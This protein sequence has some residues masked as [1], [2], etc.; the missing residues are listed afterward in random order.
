MALSTVAHIRGASY[1]DVQ[2]I[3][4]DEFIPEK[5][6][7]PI[8]E[9]AACLLNCYETINRN[10]ELDGRPPV[11]LVGLANSNDAGNPIFTE[12]GL[13]SKVE[14]MKKK[15]QVYSL[16]YQRGI[17]IFMLDSS[18][19]SKEK[20]QTALYKMTAGSDFEQMALANEFDDFRYQDNIKSM[21]LA[22][23]KP[24]CIAGELCFYKHKSKNEYYCST[25]R[26]GSPDSYHATSKDLARWRRKYSYL[27]A[28]Y[29][30][31]IITFES[32]TTEIIFNKYIEM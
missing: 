3:I 19:I 24:I 18:R 27:W 8:K 23:Y 6:M 11:Q 29:L 32:A 21:P 16:D 25:T 20:Q 1:D 26:A 17:G 9:E 5:H 22:E 4:F 7:R 10:R 30:R 15:G 28:A 31:N 14:A 12:L 13:I 2:L